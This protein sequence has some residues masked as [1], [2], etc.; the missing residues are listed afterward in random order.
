MSYEK[1]FAKNIKALRIKEGMTQKELAE[2]S[3]YSDK[4]V[5][6]WEKAKCLPSIEALM[7]VSSAL[8]T[9]INTLLSD[10]DTVY[11]LGIDGGGTKTDLVLADGSGKILREITVEQCNPFDVGFE[12]TEKVLKDAIYEIC[13]G[14]PLSS[15]IA[16]AG[17]AGAV[18]GDFG[19]Y[20]KAFFDKL[21]F[22]TYRYGSDNENI[23]KAGLG[24]SNGVTV[25]MG[26][27]ICVF[28]VKGNEKHR[29]SGW[30][31]LFDNGG[32]AYNVGRDALSAYFSYLD[33]SGE[34]SSLYDRIN[35]PNVSDGELLS[36]LYIGGKKAIA[37]YA[38]IVFEE[39]EKGDVIAKEII[40]R[41]VAEATRLI[42]VGV[43]RVGSPCKCV[44]TGGLAKNAISRLNELLK[45]TTQ[46]ELLEVKPVMGALEL[47]KELKA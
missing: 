23:I 19:K 2:L 4:T 20:F 45:G 27:G 9:D 43:N 5:S 40:E 26:T 13:Y 1:A 47:A 16:Y 34:Y 3:G 38:P 10:N 44:I 25:I 33:G 37:S 14:I 36:S 35:N 8:K 6:K 7:R 17:I 41:N 28:A 24:S 32:S 12:K 29:I 31:Y 42:K 15:V 39:A 21:G 11:Y 18:A 22:Y 30:G 46:V